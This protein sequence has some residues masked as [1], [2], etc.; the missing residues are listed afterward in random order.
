M[1]LAVHFG[2]GN[3]GRGF[4]GQ[5]L[6]QAGY[7]VIFVDVNQE[8]VNELNQR[9]S[10][11]VQLATE[12]N[13]VFHVDRVRAL[14]GGDAEAV[15]EAIAS[16]DLVTTAVGVN[17]LPHLAQTIARGISRR[18]A[19]NAAPLNLIA[20]ENKIGSS[21]F[22]QEHVLRYLG[23]EERSK[24]AERI[25][26]PNAAVDRIVPI[27]HHEDKLLV[28]VEPFFEWVVDRSQVIGDVPQIAGVTYVDDIRP[29]IERK[30]YT[31]NTGHAMLAYLG[32][33]MGSATIDEAVRNPYV[34]QAAEGVLKETAELLVAK[35][36]FEPNSHAHYTKKILDRF[37]NPMLA[38]NVTRVARNPIQKLSPDDRLVSPAMQ[39]VERGITPEHLGMAIAAALLFDYQEDPAA[40]RIQAEIKQFGMPHVLHSYT[41]IPAGHPLEQIV[42]K[43]VQTLQ[44]AASAKKGKAG[45]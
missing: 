8:L 19:R 10:Y 45:V 36:G 42:L 35:Y 34:R 27:Q 28:V 20:C 13:P 39:C 21:A 3:I 33:L 11:Q 29:Y 1:Q 25:G 44:E 41:G 16:A 15:A 38:D 24:A 14:D 40:V 32:Y 9:Q 30:L 26:F 37:A 22:L 23:E 31:V 17:V 12:G 43:H 2:A 4:I 7:E 18:L 5:L 6:H